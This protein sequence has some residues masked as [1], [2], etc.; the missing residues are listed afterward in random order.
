MPVGNLSGLANF[1]VVFR[2]RARSGFVVERTH[3]TAK[4]S[5]ARGLS[6]K[7]LGGLGKPPGME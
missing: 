1:L 3:D 6:L 5:R 2:A 7:G 4:Q